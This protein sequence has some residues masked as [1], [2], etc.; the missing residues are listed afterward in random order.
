MQR[1]CAI[2][3]QTKETVSYF[4][5]V[6]HVLDAAVDSI[7][8]GDRRREVVMS[9]YGLILTI[10]SWRLNCRNAALRLTETH[11]TIIYAVK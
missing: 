7:S 3:A 11:S 10:Y 9:I 2:D 4:P 5:H 1:A 6:F 8:A